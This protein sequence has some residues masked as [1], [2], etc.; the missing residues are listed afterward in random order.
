ML[1][2]SRKACRCLWFDWL[3]KAC[4][5]PVGTVG[6]SFQLVCCLQLWQV[7]MSGLSLA[8]MHCSL[9]WTMVMWAQLYHH[10]VLLGL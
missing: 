4:G 6:R 8:G 3:S 1:N 2:V 10:G 5:P 7:E 9:R